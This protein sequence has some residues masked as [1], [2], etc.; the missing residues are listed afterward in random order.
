[1]ARLEDAHEAMFD[2]VR[3]YGY[4]HVRDFTSRNAFCEHMEHVAVRI[5]KDAG[6]I[7]ADSDL[8]VMGVN[9]AR[10]TWDNFMGSARK[11][12]KVGAS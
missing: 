5:G 9:C 12:P 1:M 6:T 3:S 7:I 2:A 4:E 8:Q 10:W 11:R